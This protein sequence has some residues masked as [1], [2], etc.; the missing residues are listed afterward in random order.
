MIGYF[1]WLVHRKIFTRIIVSFLPVGHT[2]EDIDQFFSRLAVY[3]KRHDAVSRIQLGEGIA[4]AY[5]M[6]NGTRPKVVHWDAVPNFTDF[7]IANG[8]RQFQGLPDLFDF[9]FVLC[10]DMLFI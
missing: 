3:L 10:L 1:G 4:Q 9:L 6:R 5:K 8:L 7:L 2:H